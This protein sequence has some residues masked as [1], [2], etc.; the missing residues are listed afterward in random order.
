[1]IIIDGKDLILGRFA[2]FAAKQALLGEEVHI[3]NVELAVITGDKRKTI[4]SFKQKRE[5]GAPLVGP[6]FPRMPDRIVKRSIRGMLDYNAPRGK[7]AFAR[8][9]CHIGV[10]TQF[11]GK[12]MVS[13]EK[14][15]VDKTH[16]KYITI[17]EISRELGAKV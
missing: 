16:A 5:R 13:F 9:K 12:E 8:I 1:M 14:M 3:V 4:D 2:A 6:F 10:P 17:K 11:A 15:H 7:V